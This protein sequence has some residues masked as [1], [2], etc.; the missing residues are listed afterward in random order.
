MGERHPDFPH[1]YLFSIGVRPSAQGKGLGRKL[2]K[3]VLDACDRAEI[4]AYLDGEHPL[5]PSILGPPSSS[6]SQDRAADGQ[7]LDVLTGHNSGHSD[8]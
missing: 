3:P 8:R 7:R 6:A 2:I 1:A 5:L 4:R